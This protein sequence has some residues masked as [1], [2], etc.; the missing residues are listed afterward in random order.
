MFHPPRYSIPRAGM[1]YKEI[2]ARMDQFRMQHKNRTGRHSNPSSRDFLLTPLR[3]TSVLMGSYTPVPYLL[4]TTVH[5]NV[6]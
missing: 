3:D 4:K 2:I 6:L 5:P 1:L